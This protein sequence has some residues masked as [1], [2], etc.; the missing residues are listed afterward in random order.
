VAVLEVA[1]VMMVV[2]AV[3]VPV[4]VAEDPGEQED[5]EVAELPVVT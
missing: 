4:L 1:A 5:E 2:V 3:L